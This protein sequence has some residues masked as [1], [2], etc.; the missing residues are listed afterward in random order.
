MAW[1]HDAATNHGTF[2]INGGSADLK[3]LN[4]SGGTINFTA[5]SL[6]YLGN[7][8]VGTGGLLGSNLILNADR[9]LTLSGTTTVDAS[10]TLTLSGGTLTT[11]A[12]SS[13]NGAFNFIAGTLAI[14][15]TGAVGQYAD[16]RRH[17]Q[18]DQRQ[19]QQRFAGHGLSSFTAST[20]M[21]G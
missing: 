5:G 15:Q 8:T 11:L 13:V 19:C 1:R 3:T 14:T 4:N 18:H 9:Q 7:L 10:R 12:V 20:T 6:S 21:V 16:R 2:N 17:L